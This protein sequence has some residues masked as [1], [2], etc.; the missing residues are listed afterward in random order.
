MIII[1]SSAFCEREF[2]AEFGALPPVFLPIGNRR[3]FELQIVRLKRDLPDQKILITLPIDFEISEFDQELLRNSNICVGKFEKTMPLSKVLISLIEE[4]ISE[5]EPV[6]ILHGDTLM[7]DFPADKDVIYLAQTSDSHSW[8]FEEKVELGLRGDIWCGFFSFSSRDLI[9]AQFKNQDSFVKA[10]RQYDLSIQC[11]LVDAKGWM[12]FGHLSTYF[13]SRTRLTTE[14]QFNDLKILDGVVS[15]SGERKNKLYAEYDWFLSCPAHMK[16]Y[17]PQLISPTFDDQN[18]KYQIEYLPLIPLNELFVHGV[19]PPR[20]WQHIFWC[21]YK[22]LEEARVFSLSEAQIEKSCASFEMLVRAKTRE[23][24]AEFLKTAYFDTTC[25]NL[26]NN[27]N[28]PSVDEIIDTCL[29]NVTESKENIG[30]L[31][32]DLCLSNILF[33]SRSQRIKLL[34]PRGL[35]AFG[36]VVNFGDLRYDVAKLT[37]SILGLYDHIVANR[38]FVAIDQTD[39]SLNRISFDVYQTQLSKLIGREFQKSRVFDNCSFKEIASITVL[40]FF[41]MLPLH[42]EDKLRQKALLANGIRVFQTYVVEK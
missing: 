7:E 2:E 27:V 18:N 30:L 5:S 37:H 19:N 26:L 25:P 34:D 28:T 24:L 22:Y 41:S 13:L 29:S 21:L 39:K 38:F 32:G 17:L 42:G 23:R 9:L 31:H 36:N 40:L 35:D 4:Q 12:D 16:T 15:K 14:R 1:T 8:E 3:L 6:Y 10:I 33:D 11:K 20:Y